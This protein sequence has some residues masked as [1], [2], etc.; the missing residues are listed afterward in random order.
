VQRERRV[1]ALI[2]S[3]CTMAIWFLPSCGSGGSSKSDGG[4]GGDASRGSGGTLGGSGGI[5]GASAS[6]G[7]SGSGGAPPD[8][9]AAGATGEGGTTG[10]G[11]AG[12]SG[13]VS[14]TGGAGG[15]GGSGGTGGAG[16]AAS[17]S[18]APPVPCPSTQI[19]DLDTPNRCAAGFEP[20]HC[21]ALPTICPTVVVPVCGCD[22]QTYNNDCERQR[23]R[24]QLA[25]TGMCN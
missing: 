10:S 20:G 21:I 17:C 1:A 12:G 2:V 9:G 4:Q 25:H 24:A 23:A 16:G 5:G 22:N 14:G 8:G 3:L 18:T 19:C 13:G 6:G 15:R 7:N 11:G